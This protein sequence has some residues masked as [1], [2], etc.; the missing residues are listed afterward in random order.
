MAEEESFGYTVQTGTDAELLKLW[1]H[2]DAEVAAFGYSRQI[3]GRVLTKSHGQEITDKII[4]YERRI[5]AA[6]S[7]AGSR[8]NFATRQRAV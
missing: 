5:A 4:F 2:A 3:R 1:R 7:S 8:D 6:S